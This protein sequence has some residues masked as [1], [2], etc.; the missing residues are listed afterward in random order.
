MLGVFAWN[1]LALQGVVMQ[2]ICH[3]L[4]TAALFIIAGA[5]Y[6]RTHT[7]DLDRLG[8]LW[9]T[10]PKL[11]AMGLF[12]AMASLGLPGL[13]NFVAEIL[14]LVGAY[15]ASIPL[16]VL[17]TVGLVGA[18]I[19]SLRL[20]FRTFH[21]DNKEG[22]ALK[23]LSLREAAVLGVMVVGLLWLGLYPQPILDTAQP[24]LDVLFRPR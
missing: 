9:T 20:M 15:K 14:V 22:W 4:S 3:G 21:G 6:E 11:G 10:A 16:T 18:T 12:F 19:Y 17:A 24:T 13:G 5:I 7:R 1:R 8:G 2:M 23:D